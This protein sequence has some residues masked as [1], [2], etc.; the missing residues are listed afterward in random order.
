MAEIALPVLGLGA[1]YLL[2]N[3]ESDKKE[4][5]ENMGKKNNTL[6]NKNIQNINYPMS[7]RKVQSTPI[8]NDNGNH[9]REYLNPNQTT[10]QFFNDKLRG[11]FLELGKPK[12]AIAYNMNLIQFFYSKEHNYILEL[13]QSAN[14]QHIFFNDQ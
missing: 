6:P 4:N 9:L 13:I 10:D 1:L 11:N 14:H 8:N 7:Q 5:Y 12:K 3:K 2:S